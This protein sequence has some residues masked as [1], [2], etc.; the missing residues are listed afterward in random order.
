VRGRQDAP[1]A[2]R[3]RRLQAHCQQREELTLS[4][5]QQQFADCWP[6]RTG[7]RESDRIAAVRADLGIS[8]KRAHSLRR[9]LTL[10][11]QIRTR[12]AERPAARRSR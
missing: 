2:G 3:I 4:D 6:A 10:P 5:H 1:S 7:L 9:W 11:E 12:I 8:V